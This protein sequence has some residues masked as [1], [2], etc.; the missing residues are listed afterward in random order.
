MIKQIK[1]FDKLVLLDLAFIIVAIAIALYAKYSFANYTEPLHNYYF[2][3]ERILTTND[4][5]HYATATRDLINHHLGDEA[6]FPVASLELPSLLSAAIYYIFPISI[7]SLIFLMPIF[8]STLLAIPVFLLTKEISNRYVAFFAALLAPLTQGYINRTIGGYYDTDMLILTLP[9][10]AIYFLFR[11]LKYNHIRDTILAAIFVMLSLGWH[12]TS[13][14]YVLGLTLFLA[15]IYILIT[16]KRNARLL[17]SLGVL[18]ISLSMINI[19][20]KLIL[21]AILLHFM[22]DRVLIARDFTRKIK[23]RLKYKSLII[24]L[25]ALAVILVA[26]MDL[27]IARLGTYITGNMLDSSSI[28]IKGTGGSIIELQP[29][30]FSD[31]VQR[32]MGDN[33]TFALAL[34]GILVMFIKA[35]KTL[36]LLPFLLLSLSSLKL[37]SRFAMFG[38]PIFAMGYFYLIYS[39]CLYV[40]KIFDDKIV[41]NGVKAA[42]LI[43][44]GYLAIIPNYYYAF[45]FMLPPLVN[46]GE[47][48]ALDEI[49]KDSNNRRDI[50]I[51]WWDY[52]FMVPYYSNTHPIIS[53][54]DLDGVNHFLASEVLTNT[55]QTA[56]YNLAKHIAN[57]YFTKDTKLLPLNILERVIASNDAKGREEE[58]FS[59]L[60][61]APIKDMQ[62]N[63]V[64]IYLPISILPI[65]TSIEQFSDIDFKSGKSKYDINSMKLVQYSD[66]SPKDKGKFALNHGEFLFDSNSGKLTNKDTN[67]SMQ[68]QQFHI[69]ERKGNALVDTAK[70]YNDD[71]SKLHV[72][73]HKELNQFFIIDERTNNSLIV[74]LLVYENYDRKLFKPI[75]LGEESKAYKLI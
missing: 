53:G 33:I 75:Y 44:F 38:A 59:S 9:L 37:G 70:K 4:A 11:I 73:Y 39:I 6:F 10:F 21:V 18:I 29:L 62:T 57:I 12:K 74:Q 8:I 1:K 58:F 49:K 66:F 68:M 35:P 48:V 31:L 64:Y 46:S 55:N 41:I 3:K 50:S 54:T 61:K 14:T 2:N 23:E 13:A 32:V 20:I 60:S 47:L 34:L 27:I 67:S 71:K 52:G 19:F 72:I 26:N 17:E 30:P 7:S 22:A 5:Y 15:I 51:S 69:I 40:K 45:N 36:L 16:Y 56:A 63:N 42:A 65:T 28:A 25:V 24:F 43:A